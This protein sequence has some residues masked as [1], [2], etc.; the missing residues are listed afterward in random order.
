MSTPKIK[1]KKYF[2]NLSLHNIYCCHFISF[3]FMGVATSAFALALLLE[4]V[5][6]DTSN[7]MINFHFWSPSHFISWL[8]KDWHLE[9]CDSSWLP[10][11]FKLNIH[12]P[13]SITSGTSTPRL[14]L[15]LL[16]CMVYHG[17]ILVNP[18]ST[19]IMSHTSLHVLN[20]LVLENLL[21]VYWM[22]WSFIVFFIW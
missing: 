14:S 6:W 16:W 1:Y 2:I 12:L 18:S 21:L 19:T 11:F 10:W 5:T 7:R 4:I 13:F 22:R 9:I 15:A 8:N 3:C 17:K 20:R